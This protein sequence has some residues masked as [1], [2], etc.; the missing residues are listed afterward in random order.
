MDVEELIDSTF[1]ND[2]NTSEENKL[3][4]GRQLSTPSVHGKF[5]CQVLTDL[6]CTLNL[7]D[8]F[9]NNA[10]IVK[11]FQKTLGPS[12]IWDFDFYLH[13]GPGILL[14][15]IHEEMLNKEINKHPAS[16]FFIVQAEGD[17]R[18]SITRTADGENFNGTGP[19]RFNYSLQR[20]LKFVKKAY[21][22]ATILTSRQFIRNDED[23]EDVFFQE[24][25]TPDREQKINVAIND[26]NVNRL[27][28]KLSKYQ[29]RYGEGRLSL[30]IEPYLK[31]FVK[32]TG[33]NETDTNTTKIDL[34]LDI[35]GDD[36]TDL[37]DLTRGTSLRKGEKEENAG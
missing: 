14:N 17:P 4:L 27:E 19:A 9:K 36:R 18:A 34:D 8:W 1:N 24:Y 31:A 22:K 6:K 5:R 15:R 7:S 3:P 23:F 11:T 29:V 32:N 13:Y 10:K 2:L 33:N 37:V 16:Y 20:R 30:Y 35:L 26:L 25:F 12:D 28:N 21:E